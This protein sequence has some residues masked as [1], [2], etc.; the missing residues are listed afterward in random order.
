MFCL[1]LKFWTRVRALSPWA[2]ILS[3]AIASAFYT[4]T[5]FRLES[6]A[7]SLVL[8]GD[9]DLDWRPRRCGGAGHT[10]RWTVDRHRR[11]PGWS[12]RRYQ[13]CRRP[14]HHG[15]R[16]GD[17]G[18][19][20]ATASNLHDLTPL[21][22]A[23]SLPRSGE[24]LCRELVPGAVVMVTMPCREM[25]SNPPGNDGRQCRAEPPKSRRSRSRGGATASSPLAREPSGR[26]SA[27]E[28]A[29]VALVAA[30]TA[31]AGCP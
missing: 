20:A 2:L 25:V 16:A 13:L 9:P 6:S 24:H 15:F 7:E 30:D 10:G 18:D 5:H 14:G 3:I 27:S 21:E 17:V 26:A 11:R 8:D 19:H 22:A 23:R 31:A 12:G 1:S 28:T 4:A 29:R